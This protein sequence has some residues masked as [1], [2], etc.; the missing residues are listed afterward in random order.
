MANENTLRAIVHSGNQAISV[1]LDVEDRE[2][3]DSVGM[4]E[5]ALGIGEARPVCSAGN[6]KPLVQSRRRVRMPGREIAKGLAADHPH[7]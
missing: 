3:P 2:P 4:I 7:D 1:S 6:P 5:V